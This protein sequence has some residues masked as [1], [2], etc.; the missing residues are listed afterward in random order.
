MINN[1]YQKY[2]KSFEK[3]H[4]K[5]IKI[6]LRNKNK[7]SVIILVKAVRMFLRK[8]IKGKFSI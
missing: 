2:K 3:K 7:M 8:K 6:S 1:H 5:Y 4:V